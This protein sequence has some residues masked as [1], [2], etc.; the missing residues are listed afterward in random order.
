MKHFTDDNNNKTEKSTYILVSS[1]FWVFEAVG[2]PY[3]Y[4]LQKEIGSLLWDKNTK[5]TGQKAFMQCVVVWPKCTWNNKDKIAL[6]I[7]EHAFKT[8][9]QLKK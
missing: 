8:T 9:F 5:E 3:L 6:F 1:V 4:E 2:L 7:L